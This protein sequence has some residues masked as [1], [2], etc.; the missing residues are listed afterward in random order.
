MIRPGSCPLMAQS[1]PSRLLVQYPKLADKRRLHVLTH[2]LL[3]DA[4]EDGALDILIVPQIA[5][6]GL[7]QKL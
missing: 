6:N 7:P 3:V 1:R 2:A 4:T 5:L